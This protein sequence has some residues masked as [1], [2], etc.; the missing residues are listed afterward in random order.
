M[1][2]ESMQRL[3]LHDLLTLLASTPS[4]MS[5]PRIAGVNMR[6]RPFETTLTPHLDFQVPTRIESGTGGDYLLGMNR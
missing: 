5:L 3:C 2:I 1:P 6:K 4:R